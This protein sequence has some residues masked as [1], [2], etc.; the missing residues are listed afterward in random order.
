MNGVVHKQALQRARRLT[1]GIWGVALKLVSKFD[2]NKTRTAG[3][4]TRLNKR[5]PKTGIFFSDLTFRMSQ[6][7]SSEVTVRLKS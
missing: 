6:H 7:K 5:R 1:I 2:W 3:T 4:K